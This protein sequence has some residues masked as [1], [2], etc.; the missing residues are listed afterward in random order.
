MTDKAQQYIEKNIELLDDSLFDEFFKAA[1]DRQFLEILTV[2]TEAGILMYLNTDYRSEVVYEDSSFKRS[3][4]LS[5]GFQTIG[6]AKEYIIQ[7]LCK[8]NYRRF[9]QI[10]CTKYNKIIWTASSVG[11]AIHNTLS[12]N[13]T[14]GIYVVSTQSGNYT[15]TVRYD[16]H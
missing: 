4:Q 13:T 2:L 16:N 6:E 1:P 10:I 14:D 8:D 12:I 11:S 5:Q 3:I 15:H 9:G 7:H